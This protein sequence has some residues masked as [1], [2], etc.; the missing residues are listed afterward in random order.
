LLEQK[1]LPPL[2]AIPTLPGH[3]RWRAML[4]QAHLLLCT[5]AEEMQTYHDER[6]ETWPESANAEEFLAR[7]ERLQETIVQLQECE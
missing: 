3:A 7:I 5:A 4:C 1:G 2:P 6:S